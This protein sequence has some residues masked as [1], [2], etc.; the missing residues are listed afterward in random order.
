[1]GD[2]SHVLDEGDFQTGGL[3]RTNSGLKMCIRDSSIAILKDHTE[4]M[5]R[6]W[7]DPNFYPD[8][9]SFK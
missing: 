4:I 1:M 6:S 3:K 9:F 8:T 7:D 5:T 2:G